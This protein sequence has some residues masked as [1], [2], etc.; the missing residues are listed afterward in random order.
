M[1]KDHT[2]VVLVKTGFIGNNIMSIEEI[3]NDEA[4]L[5]DIWV[6]L[7][8]PENGKVSAH[9]LKA[10]C[11]IIQNLICPVQKKNV[12]DDSSHSYHSSAV[13]EESSLSIGI[14]NDSGAFM[15][16]TKGESGKLCK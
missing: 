7:K 11:G 1:S 12:T 3:Q 16:K 10:F 8:G 13:E 9:N 5:N 4:M 15:L 6:L 14:F 2:R